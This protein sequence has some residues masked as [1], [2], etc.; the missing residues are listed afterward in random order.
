[1]IFTRRVLKRGA[2]PPRADPGCRRRPPGCTACR[3]GRTVHLRRGGVLPHADP[4]AP[5]LCRSGPDHVPLRVE[6]PHSDRSLKSRTY[7]G[8]HKPPAEQVVVGGLPQTHVRDESHRVLPLPHHV[9]SHRGPGDAFPSRKRTR[10]G[11]RRQ[12]DDLP[13]PGHAGGTVEAPCQ[14]EVRASRPSPEAKNLCA[15][16]PTMNRQR[17]FIRISAA[18]IARPSP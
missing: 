6:Q 15:C 3:P 12:L 2:A 17:S 10:G 9:E 4:A 16:I 7:A 14:T 18:A 11:A 1:M 13:S 8:D 5:G